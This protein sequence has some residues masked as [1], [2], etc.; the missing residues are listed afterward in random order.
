MSWSGIHDGCPKHGC[1]T[2][3]EKGDAMGCICDLLLQLEDT[4]ISRSGC[5][6]MIAYPA[7][8]R[9]FWICGGSKL[10]PDCT[11]HPLPPQP[12]KP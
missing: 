5:D 4:F 3:V 9:G 11:P 12:E 2:D 8:T 6:R 10:C 7:P 1:A